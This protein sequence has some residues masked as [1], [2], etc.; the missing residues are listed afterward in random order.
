MNDSFKVY[1]V[2]FST[3]SM[4]F[5]AETRKET[6]ELAEQYMKLNSLADEIRAIKFVG[7]F[8]RRDGIDVGVFSP[9]PPANPAVVC[10]AVQP[11]DDKRW[12]W[13]VVTEQGS[14]IRTRSGPPTIRRGAEMGLVIALRAHGVTVEE[15]GANWKARENRVKVAA[16]QTDPS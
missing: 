16:A 1:R 4:K 8:C 2:V 11:V 6:R 15:A 10:G 13:V 7:W 5:V 14:D 3:G 9:G 12:H